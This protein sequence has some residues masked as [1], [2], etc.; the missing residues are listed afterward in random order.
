MGGKKKSE[1][2]K[3][4]GRRGR[5]DLSV[6]FGLSLLVSAGM[7]LLKRGITEVYKTVL[8]SWRLRCAAWSPHPAIIHIRQM[9]SNR[10]RADLAGNL[11]TCLFI[12]W[13]FE[14]L[15]KPQ[16]LFVPCLPS[17]C[18][19]LPKN[20]QTEEKT[21]AQPISKAKPNLSPS[22]GLEMFRN[23]SFPWLC[24]SAFSSQV[25]LWVPKCHKQD[26]SSCN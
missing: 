23:S 2:E 19:S 20:G 26:S 14:S 4:K 12:S 16:K 18:L 22:A 10:F 25:T 24:L 7:G 6:N 8:I 9:H 15:T 21:Q 3:W 5:G 11:S 17:A 13:Y 1:G